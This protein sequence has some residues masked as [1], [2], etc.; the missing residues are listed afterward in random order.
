MLTKTTK[1]Y[2]EARLGFQRRDPH[3]PGAIFAVKSATE[4]E[5]AVRYAIEHHQRIAVQAAGHGLTAGIDGGC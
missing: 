4:V 5:E 3:R 1:G 2:D